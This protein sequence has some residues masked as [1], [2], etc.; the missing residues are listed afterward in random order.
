MSL[1]AQI[2]HRLFAAFMDSL[3]QAIN[4]QLEPSSLSYAVELE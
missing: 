1:P 2:S 4:Y 3:Q